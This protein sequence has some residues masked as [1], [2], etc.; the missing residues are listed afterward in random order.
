MIVILIFLKISLKLFSEADM[1]NILQRIINTSVIFEI[2][3]KLFLVKNNSD[4]EVSETPKVLLLVSDFLPKINGGT[5]RPL[6]WLQYSDTNLDI[7]VVTSEA[8]V[9]DISTNLESRIPPNVK[10]FLV[11]DLDCIYR[12]AAIFS[13]RP[14]FL[15]SSYKFCMNFFKQNRPDIIIATGPDFSSFIVA[16]V[17]S[18]IYRSK[19]ILDYRDEWV[20][21]PFDFVTTSKFDI[22]FEKKCIETADLVIF[23]TESQKIHLLNKYQIKDLSSK[24]I[25]IP[26]G[27]EEIASV[28]KKT[29]VKENTK[30]VISF[31]G[32]LAEH[33]N[34]YK[35]LN[36]LE[37]F[38]STTKYEADHILVQFIGSKSDS[39]SD[40]LKKFRYSESIRI[41]NQISPDDLKVKLSE[42]DFLLLL[43]DDRFKRYIPGKVFEYIAMKKPILV[44]GVDN[45]GTE[46]EIY[47]L[48]N[49]YSQTYFISNLED[50]D[51]A[52]SLSQYSLL[53]PDSENVFFKNYSRKNLA[54]KFWNAVLR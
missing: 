41:I 11:K 21:N 46:Y 48:L 36:F 22:F 23:T 28:D 44:F 6:S 50:F 7:S 43:V 42:S 54:E 32:A 33:T 15:I 29:S 20:D 52:L 12:I 35:F 31:A 18:K 16:T 3:A 37:L 25:V 34:P 30:C 38:L 13:S 27:Y 47:S 14:L 8:N 9:T 2:F 1:A 19:L 24:V 51:K 39:V 40:S 17:L 45:C 5:Y 26:N 49:N 53:P 10:K 4:R